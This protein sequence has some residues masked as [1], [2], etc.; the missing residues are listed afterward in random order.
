[1]AT[2]VLTKMATKAFAWIAI[3]LSLHRFVMRKPLKRFEVGDLLEVM[4]KTA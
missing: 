1:M 4:P 2:K 3:M